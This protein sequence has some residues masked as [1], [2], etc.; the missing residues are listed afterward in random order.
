VTRLLGVDLGDRRI[1]LAVGDSVS[2]GI[3]PL[4]TVGRRDVAGD[5]ATLGAVVVEQAITELVIGLPLHADGR[6]GEQ[7][8]RT[9]TWAMAVT[10]ALGLPV[11]WRDERRTSVTAEARIG[12]PP[13]G[14]S[15]GAPSSAARRAW[16][17]RIDQDAA[18]S[19][20]Q[21]EL[22]ARRS[23]MALGTVPLADQ[24]PS[25]GTR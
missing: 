15:G 10:P 4:T 23:A 24:Q 7:A 3:R 20:V 21:R 14:R 16:R 18:V 6:E 13:R 2:G 1:G 8:D 25:E 17:G 5:I 9:R 11:A 19:I 12:R 22:D